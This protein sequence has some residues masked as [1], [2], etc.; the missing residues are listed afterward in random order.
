MILNI[1]N[2]DTNLNVNI[3]KGTQETN[4]SK[5]EKL[6][7]RLYSCIQ[8]PEGFNYKKELEQVVSEKYKA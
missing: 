3:S 4:A 2:M 6:V 8:L 7:K 5:R 1:R